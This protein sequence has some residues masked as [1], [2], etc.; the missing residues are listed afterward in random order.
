MACVTDR[1]GLGLSGTRR[2]A[3]TASRG[4]RGA[5]RRLAATSGS[6]LEGASRVDHKPC[7]HPVSSLALDRAG[8][9]Q[10][11]NFL[12]THDEGADAARLGERE[13]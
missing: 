1:R 7:R 10:S 3:A 6:L 13:D 2:A 8:W 11:V 5:V 9:V 4:V 12:F